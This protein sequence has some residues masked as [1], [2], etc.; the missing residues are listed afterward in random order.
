ATRETLAVAAKTRTR[1]VAATA[2]PQGPRGPAAR[3]AA[4]RVEPEDTGAAALPG[5]EFVFPETYG[6]TR[7]RLLMQ[8]PGRLFV[9]WDLSP[10]VIDELRAQIGQRAASLARLAIRITT[11]GAA[12]PL[13]V[14]L[15]RDA[16]SWYVDVP[17]RRREYR[18]EIGLMLPSGEFRSVAS[19][20]VMRTPR[21]APS[22]V[23]AARRVT[24]R[25]GEAPEPGAMGELP[26]D[27]AT[28]EEGWGETASEEGGPAEAE[29]AAPGGSSELSARGG[30]SRARPVPPGRAGAPGGSS[31]RA[32]A[33]S[34]SDLRPRR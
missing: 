27:E 5:D 16:R 33:G 3:D 14:L 9:H 25:G 8:S 28:E 15:P 11:P 2:G 34:S 22:P 23:P 31:D 17:G 21:T 29:A 6:K 30:R 26:P 1:P 4:R 7:V 20:N 24:V 10:G 12:R 32:R 13:I 18:A 19:S